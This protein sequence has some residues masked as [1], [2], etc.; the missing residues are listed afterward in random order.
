MIKSWLRP[1]GHVSNFTPNG[2]FVQSWHKATNCAAKRCQVFFLA[3]WSIS[4]M[5]TRPLITRLA[6]LQQDSYQV[7]ARIR[8]WR[9][10]RCAHRNRTTVFFFETEPLFFNYE[11]NACFLPFLFRKCTRN[12]I[13]EPFAREIH[14]PACWV[15]AM[16]LFHCPFQHD[17][18][19][20]SNINYLR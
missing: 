12:A 18:L 6:D 2:S 8:G 13:S 3:F 11:R 9:E 4:Q 16:P 20:R 17:K 14:W 5:V 1:C 7:R 15:P 10:R 19:H